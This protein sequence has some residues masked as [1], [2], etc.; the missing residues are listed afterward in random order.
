V[1]RTKIKTKQTNIAD[2][3]LQAA[4]I[5]IGITVATVVS[6]GDHHACS[7]VIIIT[8][9]CSGNLLHSIP[10]SMLLDFS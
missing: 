8:P 5:V 7:S 1:R 9:S 4:D 2:N 3:I 6:D 10:M